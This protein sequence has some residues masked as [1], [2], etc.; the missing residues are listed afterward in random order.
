M[1][2][3]LVLLALF[4]PLVA[5]AQTVEQGGA[6]DSYSMATERAQNTFMAYQG[7]IEAARK[8]QS[9]SFDAAELLALDRKIAAEMVAVSPNV[10]IGAARL[11]NLRRDA[12]DDMD[13]RIRAQGCGGP[14]PATALDRFTALS[15]HQ[16]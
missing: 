3:L 2:I 14:D 5:E 9:R 12:E 11:Q 4:L 10:A 1:P 16:D 6:A 13:R 15:T 8:C 7:A